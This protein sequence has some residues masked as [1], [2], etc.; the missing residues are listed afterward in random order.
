MG[1]AR[2]RDDAPAR[3]HHDHPSRARTGPVAP[4]IEA[5]E[6]RRLLSTG[7]GRDAAAWASFWSDLLGRP[8]LVPDAASHPAMHGHHHPHH[9]HA[10]HPAASP[11]ATGALTHTLF[12]AS[13]SGPTVSIQATTNTA[14]EGGHPGVFTLT[15]TGGPGG[16]A[17]QFQVINNASTLPSDY[18]LVD[19]N[20]NAIPLTT[21]NNVTTGTVNLPYNAQS[22]TIRVVPS[23]DAPGV[24]DSGG[25][26]V[27]LQ[28][29]N[30]SSGSSCCG[31]GGGLAYTVGSPAADTITLP[32]NDVSITGGGLTTEGNPGIAQTFDIHRSGDA[33]QP[34]TITLD[35]TGSTAVP[36]VDYST[37]TN[38]GSAA[39]STTGGTV[40][41]PAGASDVILTLTPTDPTDPLGG[42]SSKSVQLRVVGGSG[43]YGMGNGPG[44]GADSPSSATLTIADPDAATPSVSLATGPSTAV[45]DAAPGKFTISR[46]S[47]D[48][49]MTV[50]FTLGGTAAVGTD[51]TVGVDT[52]AGNNIPSSSI[53][54]GGNGTVNFADTQTGIT[55][56]VADNAE[57]NAKTVVPTLSGAP[58][59][60]MGSGCCTWSVPAYT[61]GSPSSATITLTD[62]PLT[63]VAGATIAPWANTPFS[64][65]IGTFKDADPQASPGD[66]TAQITWGDGSPATS[67][68]VSVDP[69][70][71]TTF[72]VSVSNKTF[73][74]AGTFGG[75]LTVI[76]AGVQ[77]T[78]P[79]TVNSAPPPVLTFTAGD[80]TSY[81]TGPGS[82]II[83][84][85]ASASISTP[86]G[87]FIATVDWTITG[88]N[89]PVD[90]PQ[91]AA[92]ATHGFVNTPMNVASIH[93]NALQWDWSE[94]V[95]A[96]TITAVAHYI[97]GA[98][99]PPVSL[100]VQ[101]N[102][103]K[104]N[105]SITTFG[106][107]GLTAAGDAAAFDKNAA[108]SDPGIAWTANIDAP[109]ATRYGGL[110][111]VIQTADLSILRSYLGSYWGT[112]YIEQ[113]LPPGRTSGTSTGPLLDDG[114]PA[115]DGRAGLP[116]Y[117]GAPASALAT[118][119]SGD[120][121]QIPFEPNYRTYDVSQKFVTTLMYQPAGGIWV[122]V[123]FIQWSWAVSAAAGPSGGYVQFGAGQSNTPYA[124]SSSYPNWS[125]DTFS[126]FSP[127]PRWQQI[128]PS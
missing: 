57:V 116:Y 83:G 7:R 43:C 101:V 67:E 78:A 119:P 93:T 46:S 32:D 118:I 120:S 64:G 35:A 1:E 27:T 109:T 74:A 124:A 2:T 21:T 80:G 31:C 34:L 24:T 94:V 95:G 122:P 18:S 59:V 51:Y 113:V 97:G 71:P 52:S 114:T 111:G 127:T 104:G 37:A 56:T 11:V 39:L 98:T 49:A 8:A 96:D 48:G 121:P 77:Y 55:F 75:L 19:A 107:A 65:V 68:T 92:T 23:E 22:T 58:L 126:L 38:V 6:P 60:Q 45:E 26:A 53:D 91:G 28:V 10:K 36:S 63:N 117:T 66:S 85:D 25:E 17:I 99:S 108:P 106:I 61:F 128:S 82:D 90:P 20:W 30:P 41:M 5:L 70:D 40:Q 69:I 105:I 14:T 110:I 112:Q 54:G 81:T 3:G 86:P 73:A 9:H 88:P 125:Y 50:K 12:A 44:Y 16:I 123:G 47:D 102:A 100:T 89:V 103:P 79:V 15:E 29:L 62:A 87:R 4:R 84:D 115:F 72:D 33:S 76:Q 13:V 42:P